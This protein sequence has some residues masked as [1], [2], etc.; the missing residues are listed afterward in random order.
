[1]S[2]NEKICRTDTRNYQHVSKSFEVKLTTKATIDA[3]DVIFC[4]MKKKNSGLFMN[5]IFLTLVQNSGLVSRLKT[6]SEEEEK[7][8]IEQEKE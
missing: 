2:V 7:Q 4:K 1:M 8:I 6:A 3:S 5:P